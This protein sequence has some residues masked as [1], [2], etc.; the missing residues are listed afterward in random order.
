MS[1]ATSPSSTAR[2]ATSPRPPRHRR[3]SSTPRTCTTGPTPERDARGLYQAHLWMGATEL[4]FASEDDA[5][6]RAVADARAA[7]KFNHLR[8]FIGGEGADAAYQGPDAPNLAHFQRLDERIRYLNSKGITADLILAADGAALIKAFPVVGAAPPLPALPGGALRR[9]ERHLAG[10][11][12][13]RRLRG[14]ACA[15]QGDRRGA[16]GTRR[17]PASAHLGRARHLRAAAGRWL[18]GL[19]RLRHHRRSDRRHRASA[20]RRA[21]RQPGLR[22]RRQRG[23]EDRARTTWTPRPSASACGTPP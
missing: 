18:D 10:R 20:L 1:P 2:P 15:A 9:H 11:A 19:R 23:G 5:A 3:A 13:F 22:P 14:R 21:V 6:F 12:V 4:R 17:L 7:Q 16:Q 8:G